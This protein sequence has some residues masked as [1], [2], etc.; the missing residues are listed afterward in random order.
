M[1][2]LLFER[3]IFMNPVVLVTG[4]SGG[5][6]SSIVLEFAK[7]G[8]D[9]VINYLNEDNQA[10]TLKESVEKKF[11]VKAFIIKADVSKEKDVQE[12]V[13]SIT[14]KFGRIDVLV[15]NAGIAID[16]E[17]EERTTRDWQLT[18][19]TNLIGPFL[20]SKYV[21][22]VME[23][24]NWGGKI[25]NIS[26]TNGINSYFPSSIDYDASKAALINMTHNLAIQ[27]APKI[28]VNAVAP[29]WVNT[30]MNKDLPKELVMEETAKIYKKRFA[31]P[32]EIAKVVAF[33]ASEDA[34]YVN[35]AIIK[36]DGGY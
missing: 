4:G 25:I 23:K 26:S 9:V 30:D 22:K 3:G 17:F 28:N 15:N 2:F 12:M 6:G 34:V 36:V 14:Q 19:N 32:E 33:L 1:I 27:F 16:K 21:G 5:I 24:Q 18:L 8:Y 11:A 31:E 35:D 20:V 13:Q 7:R 10:N 29:G